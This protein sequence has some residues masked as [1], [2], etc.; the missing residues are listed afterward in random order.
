M[1]SEEVRLGAER[2]PKAAVIDGIPGYPVKAA[3]EF[4]V[5]FLQFLKGVG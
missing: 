2:Q 3:V 1:A 5:E 4:R